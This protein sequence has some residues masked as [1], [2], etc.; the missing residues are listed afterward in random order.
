MDSKFDL[1]PGYLRY[2]SSMLAHGCAVLRHTG[3]FIVQ[4]YNDD[5]DWL[6]KDFYHV[7]LHGPN[8]TC[9]CKA[10]ETGFCWHQTFV[11]RHM[12]QTWGS[13]R[14]RT[15]SEVFPIPCNDLH[16]RV[17]SVV[18]N[19]KRFVIVHQPDGG[20]VWRCRHHRGRPCGHPSMV[21]KFLFGSDPEHEEADD[22]DADD[23]TD[24][25]TNGQEEEKQK[26][27]E[28]V[29]CCASTQPIKLPSWTNI[30]QDDRKGDDASVPKSFPTTLSPPSTNTC[31]PRSTCQKPMRLVKFQPHHVN[32]PCLLYTHD[33][34]LE[35]SVWNL[36]CDSCHADVFYDGGTDGIFNWDNKHLVSHELLNH[37]TSLFSRMSVSWAAFVKTMR[38]RYADMKSA[39][40]FLSDSLF[41]NIWRKFFEMQVFVL[42]WMRVVDRC[43]CLHC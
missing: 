32:S 4:G 24:E 5:K 23:P 42:F 19:P 11:Q 37:F 15:L 14:R 41:S 9:D 18:D 36:H 43:R 39:H 26:D 1:S 38:D 21:K 16:G 27:D 10:A 12:L 20:C 25:Q 8:S 13:S 40:P 2:E 3:T 17:C 31:C 33:R 7:S 28:I 30:E 29:R 22:D 34:A 35:V 6:T